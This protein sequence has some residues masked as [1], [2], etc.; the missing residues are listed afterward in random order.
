MKN[1]GTN[2]ASTH[3]IASSR[4]TAV[5][6]ARVA[7]ARATRRPVRQLRVDVF[8]LDRRLSTRMPIA[9]AS[10]PSVMRLIVCPVSHSPTTAPIIA[11][12]ML[13]TTISALRQSRR[14]KQHH[15]CPSGTR[16][17]PLRT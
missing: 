12:G 3:S 4:G 8:D 13:T 7:T 5:L 14:N 1:D 6:A 2:T 11:S 15:R 9:S 10:P 16:R 17:A